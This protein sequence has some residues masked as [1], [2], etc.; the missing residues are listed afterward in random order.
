MKLHDNIDFFKDAIR[1]TAKR[2][3]ILDVYVE[4]DYWVTYAL[5]LIFNS[6]LSKET[7]FKGGT[8]LSKCG[9]YILKCQNK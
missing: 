4:K 8:S 3:D 5:K 7:V 6:E 9:D 1:M 2:L